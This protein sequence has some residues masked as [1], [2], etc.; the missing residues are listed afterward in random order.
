MHSLVD[1]SKEEYE[2]YEFH[3][4]VT[5]LR[6]FIWETL[7]SHYL[8]LVKNRAYN[9]DGKFT[10]A[11]QQG[12][13][14][15]LHEVL[16][17]SLLI[18]SPIACFITHKLYK[19]LHNKNI[20]DLPWPKTDEK[21]KKEKIP[22]KTEELMEMNSQIW[23]AKKDRGLSLRSDIEY[24]MVPNRFKSIENDLIRTHNIKSIEYGKELS[25]VFE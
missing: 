13:V 10:K 7:A 25:L 11:E 23:K 6:Y 18:L 16:D 2:R 8:E 15:T 21:A 20:E 14:H 4:P 3:K 17:L 1:Y 9:Q 5:K 22:F 19:D 24:A 12:A